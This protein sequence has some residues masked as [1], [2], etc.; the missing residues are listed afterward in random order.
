M[1]LL[2]VQGKKFGDIGTEELK[3][4]MAEGTP[5]IDIRRPDEWQATGVIPG[6]HLVTF[7]DSEGNVNPDFGSELQKIVSGPS[8]ELV[9][10]CQTGNRSAVLSEYLAGNAGFT[11]IANVEKGIASWISAGGE[12]ASATPPGNCWLC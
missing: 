12:T 2:D 8:D 4:K 10:I 6:S 3:A 11:N 5:V 1:E 7:F 9:I